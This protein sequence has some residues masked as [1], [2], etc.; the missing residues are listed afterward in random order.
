MVNTEMSSDSDRTADVLLDIGL[1]SQGKGATPADFQFH[2]YE[3]LF[4]VKFYE[5]VP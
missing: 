5:L 4:G 1:A 2:P 3:N